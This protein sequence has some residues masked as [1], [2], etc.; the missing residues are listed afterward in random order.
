M[1]KKIKAIEIEAFRAYKEKQT[2]SLIN[3]TTGDIANLVVIYAPNGYGKT[4]FFDA[5]E[6]LITSEIGRLNAP[7]A[8]KEEVSQEEGYILKNRESKKDHGTV[9]IITE[10]DATLIRETNKGRYKNDYNKQSVLRKMTPTLSGLEQEKLNFC[11]TN[12]LAHDKITNFL[13]SYTAGDKTKMLQIFW[14]S[15]GYSKILDDVN[16]MYEEIENRK[17]TIKKDIA[18]EENE[19]GKFQYEK[20]LEI[21]IET[22][23]I[24][25]NK[26]T[27]SSIQYDNLLVNLTDVI[28]QEEII[29]NNNQLKQ[30]SKVGIISDIS[31]LIEEYDAYIAN[32]KE[33]TGTYKKKELLQEKFNKLQ[34]L[35]KWNEK[36]TKALDEKQVYIEILNNW[37]TYIERCELLAKNA[38][39]MKY[40]EV[41]KP[42]L[43]KT[44]ITDKN[45]L[46]I[47]NTTLEELSVKK[48]ALEKE[49]NELEI[50][51]ANFF[52]NLEIMRHKQYLMDKAK[53]I[54]ACRN[55]KSKDATARI[56]ILNNAKDDTKKLKNI[57]SDDDLNILREI[58]II[59]NE[60]Q[61]LLSTIT[62][63]NNTYQ[64]KIELFDKIKQVNVLGKELI[65]DKQLTD[66]PVC[67][68]KYDSYEQL[69]SQVSSLVQDN[70]DLK[71]IT[72]EISEKKNH[73][74]EINNV[75]VQLKNVL[76]A[77][78][79]KI[80]QTL[81]QE[82]SKEDECV[83]RLHRKIDDWND[84]YQ[85]KESDN[86]II[87]NKYKEFDL[88]QIGKEGIQKQKANISLLIIKTIEELS[89]KNEEKDKLL[90]H[91]QQNEALSSQMSLKLLDLNKQERTNKEEEKYITLTT[92]L[93]KM[94]FELVLSQSKQ[95]K[96]MLENNQK[97]IV[98][99]ITDYQ[100]KIST[101]DM[102]AV[103]NE[104]DLKVQNQDL[105]IQIQEQKVVIDSY[106][107]R[108]KK[109][110]GSDIGERTLEELVS[111][112][113]KLEKEL[114]VLKN[115][116]VKLT[117]I[118][119]NC[120]RLSEQK[121]WLVKK[122]EIEVKKQE[123]DK[124]NKKL[125]KLLESIDDI[126]M[127]IIEQ[128]N[129]YFKSN[130][131][132]E[133]YQK[134]DPHPF[135]NH[136]I[137]ET[138][139]GKKGLQT[140]ISSCDKSEDNKIS[141]ML[142]LSSAQVNILS[143]CIFLAK[144][145]SENNT[146]LN[147]IFIDDPIQHLDGINLLAFIDLLRTITS[148]L[149]RQIVISTH[150]EQF[151]KLLKIKMDSNYY[152]ARFLELNSVGE[153]K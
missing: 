113:T 43:D 90:N 121:S 94:K 17:N 19:L 40:I 21:T 6:W 82:I 4:S 24:D 34:E 79:K 122:K 74:G 91:I 88:E 30:N 150:N 99:I 114:L 132:N 44:I 120:K 7:G 92:Y 141:P 151:Y 123:A 104:E 143:L 36:L 18:A 49:K 111:E 107:Y 56:I 28:K 118:N 105:L 29:L 62:Q 12:L 68:K 136:I 20:D 128:T 112:K 25:Y 110:I 140:F 97:A 22:A 32:F 86:K 15:K 37:D 116:R 23:I 55:K 148:E 64:S 84:Y 145:L 93:H 46:R 139:R 106:A 117:T 137:F 5:I 47:T 73:Y 146:T 144:V 153:V 59:E 35:K 126:E 61:K 3:E 98:D 69:L 103:E 108:C 127:Y 142:Y 75:L 101:Y 11:T 60:K 1:G 2:F 125:E 83:R 48:I 58:D 81:E 42:E 76:D 85:K 8:M 27:D 78:R 65:Q 41:Q 54:I 70:Q 138:K 45:T 102:L 9:Q 52:E 71:L 135:M 39:E 89:K 95:L 134:I 96:Q 130:L 119:E 72:D 50:D 13:Q 63:L 87:K 129:A 115:Q 26:L 57:L 124:I 53:E 14:D 109:V 31:L 80:I 67:H 149:N 66:C 38:E 10:D 152:Q 133:I 131:I 147:T 51:E 33:Y 100:N 16:A 77:S